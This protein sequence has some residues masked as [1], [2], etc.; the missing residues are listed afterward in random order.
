MTPQKMIDA[1]IEVQQRWPDA[2]I[3]GHYGNAS[4][5]L[6]V[7]VEQMVVARV[8][9]HHGTIDVLARPVRADGFV[10]LT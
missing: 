9:C 5:S 6:E 7:V 4:V 10:R 8:G 3:R 1:L 2:A